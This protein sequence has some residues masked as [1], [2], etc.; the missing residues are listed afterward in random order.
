MIDPQGKQPKQAATWCQ[1]CYGGQ[2]A[3]GGYL[4]FGDVPGTSEADCLIHPRLDNWRL[5]RTLRTIQ[6]FSAQPEGWTDRRCPTPI[7]R[8]AGWVH[9]RNLEVII[10]DYEV[11]FIEFAIRE[12]LLEQTETV[13]TFAQVFPRS[14]RLTAKGDDFVRQSIRKGEPEVVASG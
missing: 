5:V 12:G 11:P 10:F 9:R 13:R 2:K 1:S 8:E 3:Q 14:V 4:G 7:T 6:H